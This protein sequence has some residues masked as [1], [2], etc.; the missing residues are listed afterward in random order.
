MISSHQSIDSM[1][2]PILCSSLK[3]VMI[4]DTLGLG[5]P[6]PVAVVSGSVMLIPTEGCGALSVE[7]LAHA[8]VSG[9][10]F[11]GTSHWGDERSRST[12]HRAHKCR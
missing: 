9:R 11:G 3:D 7:M 12:A 8:P 5:L 6:S 10:P 4:P 1:Q 2:S